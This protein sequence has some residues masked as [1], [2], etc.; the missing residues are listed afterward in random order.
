MFVSCVMCVIVVMCVMCVFRAGNYNHL[1]IAHSMYRHICVVCMLTVFP[2]LPARST[3]DFEWFLVKVS[4]W[5]RATNLTTTTS[6]MNAICCNVRVGCLKTFCSIHAGWS[7]ASFGFSKG[8][9]HLKC[10]THV[11]WSQSLCPNCKT[12]ML[13]QIMKISK[14][15]HGN[16]EVN[17]KCSYS[18]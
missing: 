7:V 17:N 3:G 6:I 11:V 12:H 5:C 4:D 8:E 14:N 16:D 2:Y 18:A 1:L 13:K 9:S 10:C 15:G